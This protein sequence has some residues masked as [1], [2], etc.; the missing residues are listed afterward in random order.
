[1]IRFLFL[2][3]FFFIYNCTPNYSKV[4]RNGIDLS[5]DEWS[6]S[7]DDNAAFATKGFS[8]T[9]WEKVK[10]PIN[11]KLFSRKHRGIFWLRRT[12][13]IDDDFIKGSRAIHLGKVF[14]KDEVF[15]NGRLVGVNGYPPTKQNISESNFD[16]ERIYTLPLDYIERGENTIAIK[17]DSTSFTS[18][19]IVT[20]PIAI[21]YMKDSHLYI[22][23]KAIGEAIFS[24]IFIFIGI[25]FIINYIKMK[26]MKENLAF[27]L[28]IIAFAFYQLFRNEIV[29]HFLDYF[30]V[31]KYLE[32]LFLLNL[33]FLYINFFQ[34]FFNIPKHKYLYYYYIVNLSIAVLLIIL[35]KPILWYD[36]IGLWSVHLVLILSISLYLSYKRFQEQKKEVFIY[37]IAVGY[38]LFAVIKEIIVQGGH[39]NMES[40]IGKAFL[41][42]IFLNTA[43]LRIRFIALKLNILKRYEQLNELDRLRTKLFLY[44]DRIMSS[45]L[46]E[47]KKILKYLEDQGEHIEQSLSKV[48]DIFKNM[49]SSMD[50]IQELSR[51]ETTSEL[52]YIEKVN[53][54][55]FIK[56]VIPEGQITFTIKVDSKYHIE[57]N[58][59]LINS[60]VIRLI[61]FSGFKDFENIDLIIT[62]DLNH[63]IH[64]RFMLYNKNYSITQKLYKELSDSDKNNIQS[65]RWSIIKEILRLLGGS[66]ETSLINK[67]YLRIDLELAALPI[68]PEVPEN[69]QEINHNEIKNKYLEKLKDLK[70]KLDKI[71]IPIFK[72]K[73]NDNN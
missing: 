3:L 18:S 73:D 43:A 21:T 57:N 41:L 8:H 20:G 22:I 71:S 46:E 11:L 54:V 14:G 62:N 40:S 12:I 31:H 16:R 61:D 63:K 66:I 60:L 55:D 45:S 5:L 34:I 26:E 7:I 42:F 67:K 4:T 10:L 68:E 32:Y 44:M 72:K 69:K 9:S 39:V 27:S 30:I 49:Q 2:I 65:I 13:E 17:I 1:M 37:L 19:G 29:F 23:E 50:D 52:L 38:L 25:F 35:R 59:E 47:S 36:I 56:N 33:P 64:F 70:G 28:F 48:E 6:V 53:F 51:L 58:L 24:A 15:F